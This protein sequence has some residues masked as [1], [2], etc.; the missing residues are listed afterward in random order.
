MFYMLMLL[1]AI[2]TTFLCFLAV[3]TCVSFIFSNQ[4][5]LW[6][7]PFVLSI[8]FLIISI[9]PLY[10]NATN[11]L[12]GSYMVQISPDRS[13]RE[14]FP[15]VIVILWYFM[16]LTLHYALKQVVK[17]NTYLSHKQKNLDESRYIEKKEFHAYQARRLALKKLQVDIEQQTSGDLYPIKWVTFYDQH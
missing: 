17:D 5:W 12:S 10:L 16:I 2:V 13:V 8:T 3:I 7:L 4:R 9:Q 15:L 14:V 11:F 1:V 6:I